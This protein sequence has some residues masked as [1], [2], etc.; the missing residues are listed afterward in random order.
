MRSSMV[1]F[2]FYIFDRKQSFW[3]NLAP[4]IKIVSLKQNLVTTIIFMIFW[5]KQSLFSP[6]A[7]W[8]RMLG[9]YETSQKYCLAHLPPPPPLPPPSPQKKM[10][11]M[12]TSACLKYFASGCGLIRKFLIPVAMFTP[13]KIFWPGISFLYL[14]HCQLKLTI[15]LIQIFINQW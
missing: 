12:K 11:H 13:L 2:T 10:K 8:L 4:Q 3:A 7:K 1:T 14:V 9:N 6:Q 15:W 5:E